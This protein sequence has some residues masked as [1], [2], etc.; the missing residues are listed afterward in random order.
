MSAYESAFKLALEWQPEDLPSELK[1]RDS[2]I[3]F[4]R[5]RLKNEKAKIEREYRHSG[6]TTDIYVQMSNWFSGTTEVFLEIKRDLN[7]KTKLNRLVGQIEDLKPKKNHVLVVLCGETDPA[8]LTRL[9]EQYQI[10]DVWDSMVKVVVKHQRHPLEAAIRASKVRKSLAAVSLLAT[11]CVPQARSQRTNAPLS[12][13]KDRGEYIAA[14]SDHIPPFPEKLSGYRSENGKDFWD[15]PF[16]SKG[17]VRIFEGNGWQGLPKFP[18]TMNGCSSGVFMIRWRS[19]D[20]N[21]RLESSVRY[22]SKDVSGST[23]EGSFG[24]MS[25]TN[26]EQPMFRFAG[27]RNGD[28]ATLVDVYYELKFWQAAP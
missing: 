23:K 6:T 12:W 27:R 10:S 4:L 21:V 9:K 17:T 14:S 25:G 22:S 28:K 2:L 26:C 8:L 18:N 7:Q 5:E 20:P 13:P 1:Y 24:F 3:A 19:S 16:S 11:V 15:K